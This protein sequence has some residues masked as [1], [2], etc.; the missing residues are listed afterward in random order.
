MLSMFTNIAFVSIIAQNA[1]WQ[2]KP[3]TEYDKISRI[4]PNLYKADKNGKTG[5]ITSDGTVLVELADNK[6]GDFYENIALYTCSDTRGE[7]IIGI[8][9]NDGIFHKFI[10]KYYTLNG[11]KFYS[12]ELLS[13]SNENGKTGYIDYMGNEVLGF[14]GKYDRIKP[15]TE[16]YAAVFKN[17]K[18]HL[19]DK[20]GNEVRFRF[21]GG[22]GS[23]AGGTNVCNG[24]VHIIEGDGGFYTYDITQ[25]MSGVC[26]K[27]KK[28]KSLSY[29]YLYCYSEVSGRGKNVPFTGSPK[30]KNVG[31]TPKE[32]DGLFGY[33]I[34]ENIILPHQFSSATQFE[35]GCAVVR[36]KGKVGILRYIKN[37]F[38]EISQPTYQHNFYYGNEIKCVFKINTP[39]AWKNQEIN[40]T[41]IDSLGA[42]YNIDN[43]EGEYT[44]KVKPTVT[45]I[46]TFTVKV[47]AQELLLHQNEISYSFIKKIRC[48]IC[49]KDKDICKGD[50]PDKEEM[51]CPD[52]GKKIS[53]CKYGGVHDRD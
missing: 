3:T 52:C 41:V 33:S 39:D 17:K 5:L 10:N 16:G 42:E 48:A 7:R 24:L 11:Q 40:V 8:I 38:F 35:D 46:A 47:N 27:A 22:I 31:I 25:G 14:D 45:S 30:S 20:E 49:G 32:E 37:G 21:P 1:V 44:F 26:K 29:D 53:E 2:M 6:L 23:I 34:E 51:I 15:F 28:P 9:T 43:I 18:Y 50:H 4:A 12:D 36:F 19:I 13:V